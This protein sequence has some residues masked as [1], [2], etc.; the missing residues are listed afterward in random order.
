MNL[1]AKRKKKIMSEVYEIKPFDIETISLERIFIDKVFASQF[2]YTRKK[3]SDV[4]KHIYD[5]TVLFSDD[6]IQ[7]FLH[8]KQRLLQMIRYERKEELKRKGGVE[9]GELVAEFDYFK[10]LKINQEFE[11][12]FDEM[13]RIYVFSKEIVYSTVAK[14]EKVMLLAGV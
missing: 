14:L 1:Q 10:E 7:K 5:L 11:T 6:K 3:Y 9:E 4:A 12:A 13:Q 8:D 2:Y